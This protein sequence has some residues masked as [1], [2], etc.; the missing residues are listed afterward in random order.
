MEEVRKTFPRAGLKWA[1]EEDGALKNLF[2]VYTPRMD[3][4]LAV[5][6]LLACLPLV[7]AIHYFYTKVR[8]SLL[9][10]LFTIVSASIPYAFIRG[11]FESR[12]NELASRITEVVLALLLGVNVLFGSA[13]GLCWADQHGIRSQGH[14]IG[15]MGLGCLL[16]PAVFWQIPI[17]LLLVKTDGFSSHLGPQITRI[18]WVGECFT[19]FI[20]FG[21]CYFEFR[22]P[23]AIPNRIAKSDTSTPGNTQG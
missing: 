15:L 17:G 22:T 1:E 8:A 12:V 20:L 5:L 13:K 6:I 19:F 2:Q 16:I 4:W 9:E 10:F 7:L 23:E 21:A 3:P 18:L 14:R 11:Q